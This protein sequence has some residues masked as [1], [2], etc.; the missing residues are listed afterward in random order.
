MSALDATSIT[1][2]KVVIQAF[3]D[4]KKI[5]VGP[6]RHAENLYGESILMPRIVN[7]QA[8]RANPPAVLPLQFSKRSV[9]LSFIDTVLEQLSKRFF[10][11]LVDCIKLKIFN[12]ICLCKAFALT[13]SE[14]L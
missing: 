7:R 14:M 11:D 1:S 5:F 13:P 9:F 6:F 4:D 2:D 8:N 10:S 3:R 12:N